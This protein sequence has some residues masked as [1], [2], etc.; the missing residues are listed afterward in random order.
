MNSRRDGDDR[1]R[2]LLSLLVPATESESSD[3]VD[4]D[5][6]ALLIGGTASAGE[7]AAMRAH[8]VVCPA[9][10]RLVGR[11]LSDAECSQK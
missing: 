8:L 5:T 11:I 7:L 2:R 10:R 9:C 1:V 4:D 6:L 3:H